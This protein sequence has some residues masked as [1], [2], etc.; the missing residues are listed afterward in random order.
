M[1]G[2]E[3]AG[4]T[5]AVCK[6]FEEGKPIPTLAD[7]RKQHPELVGTSSH[8]LPFNAKQNYYANNVQIFKKDY[9]VPP[10]TED[11]H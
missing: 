2:P 5:L 6:A 10:L 7:F 4:H 3:R 8:R 11:L 1:Y 9:S